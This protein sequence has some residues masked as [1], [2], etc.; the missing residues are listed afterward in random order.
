MAILLT[1]EI[2]CIAYQ[3]SILCKNEPR[4]KIQPAV[5]WLWAGPPREILQGGIRLHWGPRD[6]LR[7]ISKFR[8]WRVCLFTTEHHR[9]PKILILPH[10]DPFSEPW[11]HM[12]MKARKCFI[13]YSKKFS[14]YFDFKENKWSL[15]N[16]YVKQY[17]S[18]INEAILKTYSIKREMYHARIFLFVCQFPAISKDQIHLSIYSCQV[19]FTRHN[20][21]LMD[22]YFLCTLHMQN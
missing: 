11:S 8:I 13:F 12:W 22:V 17:D 18:T 7:L 4:F 21:W 3:W 14:K 5:A 15:F 10:L 9:T 6:R 1:I 20:R 16:S 19:V 2:Y